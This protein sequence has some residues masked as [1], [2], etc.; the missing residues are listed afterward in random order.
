MKHV[1]SLLL[2]LVPILLYAQGT[3][4]P[5]DKVIAD[6]MERLIENTEATL[7]Y[8]DLQEQLEYHLRNKID[9]NKA[10]RETFLR[11]QFLTEKQIAAIIRHRKEYGDFLTIYE[12][13]TI[14]ELDD[15][16]LYFLS[17]FVSVDNE[18]GKDQTP[19]WQMVRK[20]RHELIL[21]HENDFQQRA[22]YAPELR[23]S[24]KSYYLGSPYRYVAR[25]RF[26][27]EGK[28]M[29]G[30][31]AEKDMGEPFFDVPGYNRF[32]F[33]SAHF[34]IRRSG[35][36]KTVALGD[37]QAN[38]GQ[39]LSFGSGIAARKSAY[40]LNVRR[41][42]QQLR[43]YR[44][45]NENEFLRGAALTYLVVPKIEVTAFGSHKAISTN[46]RA[47]LDTLE[48]DNGDNFSSFQVTGLHRT[49]NELLNRYNVDQTIGGGHVRYRG[50]SAEIGIT[51]VYTKYSV[52]FQAGTDPYQ[53]YNFSGSET[54]NAGVDYL[55][56]IGNVSVFGEAA[57]SS[58]KAMA[59]ISGLTIPLHHTLDATILYRNYA[60]DY[61]ATFSNPFGENSDGRNEE[62]I[63]TG[64]SF[65][66]ARQ[67]VLNMYFDLYRSPWLRFLVDAPSVGTDFLGEV[68]YNPSRSSQ[69]YLRYKQEKKSR[70]VPDND[71]RLDYSGQTVR[72]LV[73]F[74]VQVKPLPQV[75][76]KSRAE[77]V[78]FTQT[79]TAANEGF[80]I[81]Q[82]LAWSPP[83]SAFSLSARVVLFNIEDFNARIY[84]NES[85][86][87]YQYAVPV[88]QNSGIRFYALTHFRLRKGIDIW[89]KYS[90]TEYSN[91]NTISSGLEQIN[92]SVQSD[93][94]AQV[95]FIL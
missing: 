74:H 52:P 63:Y 50:E 85:D 38:F 33:N 37:F 54:G 22:G 36:L 79:S 21:L 7:D 77:Y 55:G 94:R 13:Q 65:K 75:T 70:N 10:P 90:R 48:I 44:S 64:A 62:G 73:R 92:G 5:A 35:R 91:I 31:S 69:M 40:V 81:F 20:G 6:I 24:G 16:D 17:Y 23:N 58:N 93:L 67:W 2:L 86:V 45:L 3:R 28:L 68:Q 72:Q 66:P 83:M 9:L 56:Y 76:S 34:F 26:N 80:L 60:K 42:Y 11:L 8:T 15:R 29:F 4:D 53:L 46:Y 1:A 49:S 12:L 18:L 30:Y 84:V 71:G 39:G 25:Y 19:F 43:P 88:F 89:L 41:S 14:P 51:G 95:R 27:Y 82:D 57:V 47:S 61:L 32:D 87:L 59:V 78:K